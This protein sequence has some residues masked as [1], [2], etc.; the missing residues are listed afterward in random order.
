MSTLTET[1]LSLL[2]LQVIVAVRAGHCADVYFSLYRKLGGS[3]SL[4]SL[5]ENP[6]TAQ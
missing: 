6:R 1:D 4:Q 3:L 5:L 2:R